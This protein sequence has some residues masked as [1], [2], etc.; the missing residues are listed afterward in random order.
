M[1]GSFRT[2]YLET[3]YT[4]SRINKQTLR[5]NYYQHLW[6]WK[7]GL[8][9][10]ALSLPA[11]CEELQATMMPPLS[12]PCS[13]T[14]APRTL[15]HFSHTMPSRPFP[16]YVARLWMLRALCPSNIVVPK[17]ARKAQG[18]CRAEQDSSSLTP[19]SS[20]PEVPQGM[21]GRFG[22]QDTLLTQ[23]QLVMIILMICI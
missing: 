7:C 12:L 11:P 13:G 4:E 17:C 10:P 20:V 23:I 3:S 6:L 8:E 18:E 1:R 22:C 16:V 9:G 15:S 2:L 21:V 5:N 19:H 14:H